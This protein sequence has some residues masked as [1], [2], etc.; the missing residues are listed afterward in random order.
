[1]Q[2]DTPL[3]DLWYNHLLQ[4]RQRIYKEVVTTTEASHD[5][6]SMALKKLIVVQISIKAERTPHY[7]TNQNNRSN[8]LKE[9]QRPGMLQ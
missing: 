4:D 2:V 5:S 1:M 9:D 3:P 7:Q 6:M 8:A